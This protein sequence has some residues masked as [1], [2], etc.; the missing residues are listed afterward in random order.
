MSGWRPFKISRPGDSYFW[1]LPDVRLAVMIRRTLVACA[2]RLR[3]LTKRSPGTRQE[4]GETYGIC[5][6]LY[7][8]R[9]LGNCKQER[10]VRGVNSALGP[11]CQHFCA[12]LL[13]HCVLTR[14]QD[15]HASGSLK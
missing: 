4:R 13:K 12:T 5:D 7:H 10:G 9:R 2:L 11:L 15:V 3:R 6:S 1:A 14:D 8:D